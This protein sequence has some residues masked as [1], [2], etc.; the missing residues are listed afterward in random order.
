MSY[1]YKGKPVKLMGLTHVYQGKQY[2]TIEMRNYLGNLQRQSVQ[3]NKLVEV[4]D[5]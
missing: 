5:E 1:L 4:C 3:F 2:C